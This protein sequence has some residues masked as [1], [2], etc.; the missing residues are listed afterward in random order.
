MQIITQE[1][2]KPQATLIKGSPIEFEDLLKLKTPRG[3]DTHKPISHARLF[4][5]AEN[6]L[7]K[8]GFHVTESHHSLGF[9]KKRQIDF[10]SYFGTMIVESNHADYSFAVGLR[11]NNSKKFASAM[12]VGTRVLVCSNMAFSG[13]IQIARKHTTNIREDLPNLIASAVGKIGAYQK[14]V[15]QQFDSYKQTELCD[16]QAHDMMVRAARQG[17]ISYRQLKTVVMEWEA[18]RHAEFLAAGTRTAWTLFNAFTEA[19][20]TTPMLYLPR[21]TIALHKMTDGMCLLA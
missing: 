13:E 19:M 11:N 21:K 4:T 15:E 7:N 14:T 17:I 3:T 16:A 20:K 9:L 6:E 2:T 10:D 1:K 5:L 8:Q 12:A 18:P